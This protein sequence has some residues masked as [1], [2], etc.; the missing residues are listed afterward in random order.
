MED[1]DITYQFGY[2]LGELTAV[3]E[4]SLP[5]LSNTGFLERGRIVTLVADQPSKIDY[6]LVE[7]AKADHGLAEGIKKDDL[8]E[9]LDRYYK[10][11]DQID[12]KSYSTAKDQGFWFGYYHTKARGSMLI[13]RERIGKRIKEMR[14]AKGLTQRELEERTGLAHNHI[15]RIEAGRYNVSI[16]TLSKIATALDAEVNILDL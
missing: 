12:L 9:T 14:E 15:A 7:L 3:V 6:W 4:K 13:T 10:L 16:D 8:I 5:N 1:K 11:L 2:T